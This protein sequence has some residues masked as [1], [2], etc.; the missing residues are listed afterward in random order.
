M[1]FS[2]LSISF[3]Q[4]INLN[5]LI[6]EAKKTDKH[7]LVFLHMTGCDYCL[8]ME[9]FTFDDDRV[10]IAIKKNFI[11]IDINVKD[12]GFVSFDGTTASKLKFAKEIGYA[13]YPS[14]LFFDKNG[15]LVY[16][17]VGYTDEEDFLKILQ[18][19][20]TKAYNDID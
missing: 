17:K 4:N 10:Q 7:L 6:L 3:A 13:M 15:E 11:F 5:T 16:D 2:V 8:R 9:E 19:V 20:S 12:E 1:L 14:C 18:I